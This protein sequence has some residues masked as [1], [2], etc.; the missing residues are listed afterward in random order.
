MLSSRQNIRTRCPITSALA[1]GT[2]DALRDLA[3]DQGALFLFDGLDEARDPHTRARVLESVADFVAHAGP[4]CRF[5]LTSRPYAWEETAPVLA[6]Q[7]D[8]LALD[9]M[10]VPYTLADFEPGQIE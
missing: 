8:P 3:R 2:A 1:A 10:F 7:P 6:R 4:K 9:E 5:L